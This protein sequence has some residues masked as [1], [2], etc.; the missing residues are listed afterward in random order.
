VK[1][2]AEILFEKHLAELGIEFSREY[3]FHP[4]RL[5]R[6]DFLLAPEKDQVAVEIEG[7]IYSNGRHNRGKGYQGDLDKYNQAA[8]MGYKVFRF[9]SADVLR[10]RAKAFLAEHLK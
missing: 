5:W 9:S 7:G 10:G 6:F 1:N 2:E 8:A 3:K 4:F